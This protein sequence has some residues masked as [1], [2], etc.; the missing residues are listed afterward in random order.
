MHKYFNGKMLKPEDLQTEQKY[1]RELS[2]ISADENI[3]GEIKEIYGKIDA[4]ISDYKFRSALAS[5]IDLARFGNKY[6]TEKEPWKTFKE[7]QEATREVLHNCVH[8]IAHLGTL[9]QPFLPT[10]S[11]KIFDM[12]NLPVGVVKYDEELSFPE[13]HKL[14]EPALLFE[15]V[16]DEV[17]E[18]QIAKLAKKQEEAIHPPEVIPAKENIN[19]EHFAALDIRVGTI[20][21]AERVAKTKKLL[22]LQIDTGIDKRTV[23]SGIAEH[24]EPEAIIG[25][26]VSILVNLEPREIKGILSQ[27]MILMAEN[28]EGKL[29]F[30]EPGENVTQGSVIR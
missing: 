2:S 4:E 10:T 7:D 14:R 19:Y 24:F 17:I 5:V 12:L 18:K 3:S 1:R 29:F 23:V 6:L 9:L 21:A 25:K 27:G 26:Q 20:L 30:V 8:I 22:K 28:S 13:G 11:K 16:E 15:K